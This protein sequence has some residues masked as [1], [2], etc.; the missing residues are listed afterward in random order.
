MTKRCWAGGANLPDGAFIA[1]A[2]HVSYADPFTFLHFLIDHDRYAKIMAKHTLF[3]V[4]VLGHLLRSTGMIPVYRGTE[5][6]SWALQ[7]AQARLSVGEAIAVF[8]EGTV[9][10]DPDLWP[11]V[12]KTGV[13]RLALA[14]KVPLVPVGQWGAEALLPRGKRLLR[15]APR[16][17]VTVIAGQPV[18]LDDL[19]DQSLEAE[20]LR[21]GSRRLMAAITDMVGRA[22]GGT[23]PAHPFDPHLAPA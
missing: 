2:N 13:V 19:Y 10:K 15:P 22:R 5:Q 23:P 16:K 6:A 4:P 12:A 1:A 17:P 21:E 14:T 18:V 20:V 8:P 11:M 9:T 3:N 7:E